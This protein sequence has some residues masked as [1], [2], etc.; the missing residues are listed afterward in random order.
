MLDLKEFIEKT[1]ED[2]CQA[3]EDAR[4]K[5]SYIATPRDD[6]HVNNAPAQNIDFDV[7]VTGSHETSN[8]KSTSGSSKG[9]VKVSVISAQVDKNPSSSEKNIDAISH[10]SRIKF[11]IPIYFQ[12]D[13]K[14]AAQQRQRTI[15]RRST[16][17]DGW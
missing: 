15:S 2:I 14:K 16:E 7:A 8:S 3:V 5:R 12:H 17:D 1:L 4:S 10:V 9:D 13:E 11:S 6:Y